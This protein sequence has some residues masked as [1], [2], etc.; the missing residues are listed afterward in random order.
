MEI[1]N[2]ILHLD[3]NLA[4]I[5]NQ[6]GNWTYVILFLIIF[7]ETGFVVTP[8]LPG[9]SLL[10]VVGTFAGGGYLN[11][12]LIYIGFLAAAILGDTVNY[13]IGHHLGPRVFSKENSRLFNKAYLEKTKEFY[14]KHGGKTIILARFVPIIRTFAPFVAGVGKMHYN[15]FLLYNVIGGVAWV[16]S[17]TWAGYFFGG[18]PIIKNNFE[19]AV[20]LII[21]I[22]LV[23]V[24]I[25]F[26]KH[27]RGEKLSKSQ[28]DHTTYQEL[29]KTFK[30]EHL[31]D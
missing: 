23:P 16:T 24:L 10:F 26:I 29:Q 21:F 9:D 18:L 2:F 4:Y 19:Y 20:I 12:W 28:L 1:F 14:I 22:S 8:F 5:I 30:K 13:W 31:N 15:T 6:F 11:I 7:A 27:K 25:E 17:L 3:E